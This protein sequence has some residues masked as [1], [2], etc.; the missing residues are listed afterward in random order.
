MSPVGKDNVPANVWGEACLRWTL[1]GQ[2]NL[3]VIEEQMPPGTSEL[4]HA[5]AGGQRA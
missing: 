5:P 4:A 1:A 2:P 3:H